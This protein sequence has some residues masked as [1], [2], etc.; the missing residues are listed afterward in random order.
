MNPHYFGNI[1][2]KDK[3]RKTIFFLTSTPNRNYNFLIQSLIKLKK[4]NLN[5]ELIISGGKNFLNLENIP[6]N[7]IHNFSF[8]FNSSFN[9]LYKAIIKSDFIILPLDP[10]KINDNSYK[11]VKVSGSIQLAYGFL[12]PIIIDKNF[13]DFYYLNCKNIIIM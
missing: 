11:T 7:L 4:D 2:I 10:K 3:K 6:K 1:K 5:F 9:E 12:K 8:K 13:A